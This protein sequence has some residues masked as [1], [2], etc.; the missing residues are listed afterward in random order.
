[1]V[2]YREIQDISVALGRESI[3]HP[4]DP[5][6]ARIPVKELEKGDSCSL[7]RLELSA[8][9]GTH[10]DTPAHFFAGAE[11]LDSFLVQDFILPARVWPAAGK[12][13]LGREALEKAEVEPGEA[14]LLQTENSTS[15]RCRKGSYEEDYVHLSPAAADLCVERGVKLVGIDYLS[16][17]GPGDP[18]YPVHRK[19]LAE[20][21]LILEG[22]D[23]GE[24]EPG[25]WTL[26]CLPLR[27]EGGEASPTRAVLLR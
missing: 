3:D 22:I 20:G 8:H 17:D 27:I 12:G 15:G 9:A 11:D 18:Q 13:A 16:A 14:L 24:V 19:L 1:M 21:I 2:H 6:F 26:L 25:R 10:L 5:P 7:S 4:G 23:L